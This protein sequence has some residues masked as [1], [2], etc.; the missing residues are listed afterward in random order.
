M[1]GGSPLVPR[2]STQGTQPQFLAWTR[3]YV[4]PDPS[5]G[6]D[7]GPGGQDASLQAVSRGSQITSAKGNSQRSH[8]E[9]CRNSACSVRLTALDE[10][11]DADAADRGQ[12]VFPAPAGRLGQADNRTA[13]CVEQFDRLTARG[14]LQRAARLQLGQFDVD[15]MPRR[16][17]ACTTQID[18]LQRQQFV[19][20]RQ[21]VW[22]HVRGL[23]R[24]SLNQELAAQQLD[25]RVAVG[26]RRLVPQ[27]VRQ[28]RR[29]EVGRPGPSVTA[30]TAPASA[31]RAGLGPR[32]RRRT[33]PGP[34]PSSVS[35]P[36]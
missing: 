20:L 11:C 23:C 36:A 3:H 6:P 19:A 14:E 30:S 31:G 17:R 1:D 4:G 28:I 9:R 24:R 2:G 18:V 10:R 32:R 25:V 16:A 22:R 33:L 12:A 21:D 13:V 29:I 34:D 8:R 7:S 26:G 5:G 27:L 15:R 35:G